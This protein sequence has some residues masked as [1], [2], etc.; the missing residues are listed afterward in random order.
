VRPHVLVPHLSPQEQ[1]AHAAFVATLGPQAIW[2][3][4]LSPTAAGLVAG[5]AA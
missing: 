1:E 5:Q 2:Q 4:Y 3:Q